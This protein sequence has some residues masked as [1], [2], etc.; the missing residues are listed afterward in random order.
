MP[1][2]VCLLI[3]DGWGISSDKDKSAIDQAK[4]PFYDSLI[5][6]YHVQFY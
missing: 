4:T 1:K 6:N 3:L 5:N 2:K